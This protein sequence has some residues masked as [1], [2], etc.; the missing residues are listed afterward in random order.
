MRSTI[1]VDIVR[2]RY[3]NFI[4]N[5]HPSLYMLIR[6]MCIMHHHI[7]LSMKLLLKLI[8]LW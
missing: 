7:Q 3:R 6:I 4:E 8:S 5:Q 2:V 1:H